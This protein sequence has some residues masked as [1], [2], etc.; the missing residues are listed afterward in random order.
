MA[1]IKRKAFGY[2]VGKSHAGTNTW[3]NPVYDLSIQRD[4]GGML[5]GRTGSGSPSNYGNWE[6][7]EHVEAEYHV[8]RGR[9]K[10]V[11][12]RVE[13]TG[14]K[15]YASKACGGQGAVAEERTGRT[16]AAAYEAKDAPLLAASTAMKTALGMYLRDCE[17]EGLDYNTDT[18][19]AAKAALAEAEEGA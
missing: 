10:V 15:W 19:E 3:G 8:T 18:Y 1:I 6:E 16:V 12:D 17:D 5:E 9:G 4:G 2:V 13:R 14:R 11:F 7:G